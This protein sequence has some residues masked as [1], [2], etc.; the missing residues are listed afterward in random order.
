[1][2]AAAQRIWRIRDGY[3]G[4]CF[5]RGAGMEPLIGYRAW[6]ADRDG[7][8]RSLALT[9]VWWEPGTQ[10][11]ATCHKP[12]H[13]YELGA[14]P[15]AADH[16]C[17]YHAYNTLHALLAHGATDEDGRGDGSLTLV[18]G[19]VEGGGR[20]QEHEL[21]WRAQYA[22]PV[23]ILRFT[24]DDLAI[25]ERVVLAQYAASERYDIPLIDPKD[26]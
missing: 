21:G 9:T 8:L 3:N 25:R 22:L 10:P 6:L 12:I 13:G 26:A 7:R 5:T 11:A 4:V 20:T 1:M 15:H 16:P 17:G 14:P 23:A 24:P 19:I 2:D 18:R